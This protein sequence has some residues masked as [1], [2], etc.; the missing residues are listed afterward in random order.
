M[1]DLDKTMI[2]W[3]S[4]VPRHGTQRIMAVDHSHGE[5][6]R[7]FNYL[8]KSMGAC[9]FWWEHATPFT[10]AAH[11]LSLFNFV[12]IRHAI[13]P[14]EAHEAFMEIREYNQYHSFH[15]RDPDALEANPFE[16]AYWG[17]LKNA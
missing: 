5:E 7:K 15:G 11:I 13:S 10:R 6:N 9:W 12:T 8:E 3:T 2:I 1:V 4:G 14:H 16:W 17:V